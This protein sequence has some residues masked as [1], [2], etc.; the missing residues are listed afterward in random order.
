M[1]GSDSGRTLRIGDVAQLRAL[2][3]PL[4]QEVLATLSRLGSASVKEMATEL[5]RAPASLYYHIHEL[6]E[7]GL[8]REV[9]RRPA[10]RRTEA[11]YG[12][13][14]QRII[15][16]R[17]PRSKAFAEA[18]AEL[19]RA[20]LRTAE[21]ELVSALGVRRSKKEP[22]DDEAIT[23]LRMTARLTPATARLARKK[24]KALARF[25]AEH[26]DAEQGETFAF[27]AAL[28]RPGPR[29]SGDSASRPRPRPGSRRR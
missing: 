12:P 10:G 22:P 8:I 7:A 27:T 3:T 28:V 17:N 18:L 2:R 11:V 4:R 21:R 15:I 16:D 13:A 9:D 6:A 24:L 14:A 26:D 20:T 29:F 25:L 1:S 19:H 5:G 23:L